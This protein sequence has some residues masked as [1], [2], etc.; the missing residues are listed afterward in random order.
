MATITEFKPEA[1]GLRVA[2]T[3]ITRKPRRPSTKPAPKPQY[4][5]AVWYSF[6][7]STPEQPVP[8]EVSV[9]V[10][11]VEDTI[12]KLKTAARYLERTHSKPGRKVEVRVQISV[13]PEL[14]TDGQPVKPAK[15]LVKFLGHEP[16]MLG[17]RVSKERVM[18]VQEEAALDQVPARH[19]KRTVAGTRGGHRRTAL[20]RAVAGSVITPDEPQFSRRGRTGARRVSGLVYPRVPGCVCRWSQREKTDRFP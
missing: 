17:R 5:D 7:K 16:F 3:P 8:L 2:S 12:R 10:A 14:G 4:A 11:S 9:R 20:P 19:R 1:H 18:G 6:T 15:S 13:E